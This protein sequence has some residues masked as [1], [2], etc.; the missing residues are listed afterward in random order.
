MV[1]DLSL[2]R[3]GCGQR[4]RCSCS[5][6]YQQRLLG[7]S[8]KVCMVCA[9][10]E[11]GS[12]NTQL[13]SLS[14]RGNWKANSKHTHAYK[15]TYFYVYTLFTKNRWDL[16]E[17]TMAHR[18]LQ[19]TWPT[20]L[21]SFA[22]VSSPCPR[23]PGPSTTYPS[24]VT[25][26]KAQEETTTSLLCNMKLSCSNYMVQGTTERRKGERSVAADVLLHTKPASITSEMSAP[27]RSLNL[28]LI[29]WSSIEERLLICEELWEEEGE[30]S[31][32]ENT[33][34]SP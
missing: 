33:L 5:Q 1:R 16:V 31:R 20:F 13:I 7:N 29:F 23:F 17:R 26:R 25:K 28:G 22:M 34:K 30:E 32:L 9:L 4:K 8:G 10:G 3:G 19:V 14:P 2:K 6:N 11:D 21:L 24:L 12:L 15:P 18:L 27:P